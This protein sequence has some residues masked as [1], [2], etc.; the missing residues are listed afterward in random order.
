MAKPKKPTAKKSAGKSKPVA[1]KAGPKKAAP[2]KQMKIVARN[3]APV[4]SKKPAAKESK[5]KDLQEFMR[6]KVMK[7]LDDGKAEDTIC[8]DVRGQS[9]ICDFLIITTGRSSRSVNALSEAVDKALRE[10]GAKN[11]R[12]EGKAAGDWA[13][14]DGGDVIVHVFRPEVRAFYRLEEVWGLEPPLQQTFKDL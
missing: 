11:V 6:D 2:Q 8:I 4:K 3:T 9:P 10:S 12:N 1:K 7:A 13:V 14:V 5:V